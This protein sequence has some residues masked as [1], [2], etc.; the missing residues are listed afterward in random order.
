VQSDTGKGSKFF[1]TLPL[2]SDR[3][4]VDPATILS[5]QEL[6]TPFPDRGLALVLVVDNSSFVRETVQHSLHRR[7][8]GVICAGTSEDALEKARMH[9]PEVILLDVMMNK[10]SGFE[11]LSMLRADPA[12]QGLPVIAFSMHGESTD[13]KIALGAI[14]FTN[15]THGTNALI[16][17]FDQGW[18]LINEP[19]SV[20]I[21]TFGPFGDER[22]KTSAQ[23]L[24]GAHIN[25][26]IVEGANA[27][28]TTIVRHMPHALLVLSH[29]G[30][31]QQL[32]NMLLALKS[33]KDL[34]SIPVVVT[35]SILEDETHFHLGDADSD[36]RSAVEY[37]GEQLAAVLRA[38]SYRASM[39]DRTEE[40]L[41]PGI[42]RDNS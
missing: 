4:H 13:N 27:A 17:S 35:S 28:I 16:E 32:F 21:I 18:R 15:E 24:I 26:A 30:E 31:E 20:L 10:C 40:S 34:A 2:H 11:I 22:A 5:D 3:K 7:G 25:T 19:P 33:V 23:L 42:L 41:E 29:D 9:K 38:N 8:Y 12:T 37:I 14:S 1:F 36:V 39:A 6:A